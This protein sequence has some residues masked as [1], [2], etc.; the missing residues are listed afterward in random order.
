MSSVAILII[1]MVLLYAGYRWY[2]GKLER[3][4]VKP[5]DKVETPA[6][7]KF[8]NV[9]FYPAKLPMLFGHHFSSIAGAGPIVGPLL[10]VAIFGWGGVFV[11]IVLGSIFIGAVHDYLSLM[12]SVRH[13]GESIATIATKYISRRASTIFSLFLWLSLVLIIAVFALTSAQTYI[14]SPELAIPSLGLVLIAALLGILVY[15]LKKP[16]LWPTVLGLILLL[17]SVKLAYLFPIALGSKNTWI[18]ILFIY[19]IIASLL[20]VWLV[21][22][23]RD[24]ISTYILY[25]GLFLGA[26]GILFAGFPMHAP[27]FTGV[28]ASGEL[29]WPSLFVIVACGAVSGFHSICASGTTAK[30]LDKE[31]QGK[32]IGYGSMIL[33]AFLAL[34]SLIVAGAGLFWIGDLANPSFVLQNALKEGAI[35]TFSRGFGQIVSQL[36]FVSFTAAAFFGMFMVNAFVLTTLDTATRLGRF[37]LSELT[38][39]RLNK[40]WATFFTVLPAAYLALSGN[41]RTIWPLFASA[42]QLIAAL[43]LLVISAYLLVNKLRAKYTLWPAI[44]MIL[45]ADVSLVLQLYK[46]SINDPKPILAITSLVLLCLSLFITWDSWLVFRTKKVNH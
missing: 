4:L 33:E 8:D 41:Y 34:I 44:F 25:A 27:I 26:I 45:T 43:A 30:Q 6:H 9:D 14:T 16:L 36:P 7:K 29:L 15:R 46:F 20:P 10:A 28:K 13:Q 31:S 3:E 2:G 37:V 40:Y 12:I 11:W 22:Q 35:V 1:G 38:G 21:L 23:P 24:Y 39:N 18:I 42:N 19:A 5:T 32:V 17:V